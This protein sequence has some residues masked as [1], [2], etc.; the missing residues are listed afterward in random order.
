MI[1]RQAELQRVLSQLAEEIDKADWVALVDQNGLL[2]S[3]VPPDPPVESDRV[4]AMAAAVAQTA[5][6]VL[7]E[8][9][10]VRCVSPP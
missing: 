5:E 10:G 6:R 1:T 4:A 7:A 9:D 3:S 2:V 8:I